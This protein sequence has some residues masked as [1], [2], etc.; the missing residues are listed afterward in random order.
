LTENPAVT[1]ENRDFRNIIYQF[2][3][4][5]SFTEAEKRAV[6]L[7]LCDGLEWNLIF[8]QTGARGNVTNLRQWWSRLHLKEKLQSHLQVQ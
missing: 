4:K 8:Q 2:L 3:E 1:I 7:R 5:Q 6:L